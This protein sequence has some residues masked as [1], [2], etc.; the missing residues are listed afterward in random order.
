MDICQLIYLEIFLFMA[1]W[2]LRILEW[3]LFGLFTVCSTGE[4]EFNYL[5]IALAPL[6]FFDI[7]H[8]ILDEY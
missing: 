6:S 3:D 8:L 4:R 1:L 5:I 7:F 2:V